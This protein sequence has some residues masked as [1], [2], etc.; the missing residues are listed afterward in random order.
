MRSIKSQIF[1]PYIIQQTEN[2][3]E[4]GVVWVHNLR[5][6]YKTQ[7]VANL[8]DDEET[9]ESTNS[10]V[11]PRSSTHTAIGCPSQVARLW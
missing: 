3:S 5:I 10:S 9:H 4:D 8:F 1:L 6:V 11:A 7:F 2:L